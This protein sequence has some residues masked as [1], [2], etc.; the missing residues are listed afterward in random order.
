MSADIRDRIIEIAE[1]WKKSK[2]NPKTSVDVINSWNNVVSKWVEDESMPLIIRRSKDKRG[3]VYKH[4]VTKRKIIVSDN[5]PATWV[6]FNVLNGKKLSLDEIKEILKKDQLPIAFLLKKDEREEAHYTKTQ[7]EFALPY[8]N[9]C[10]IDPVGLKIKGD[11]EDIKIEILKEHFIKFLSPGN[12]F[13]V[14]KSIAGLG[15]VQ[16]FIDVQ[17]DK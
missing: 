14:P 15:E 1:L 9:V 3:H 11:I 2:S 12:M 10:H 16:D 5:S 4:R 13:I 6:M 8:W 17:R 7:D